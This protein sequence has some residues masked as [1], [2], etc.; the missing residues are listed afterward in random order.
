MFKNIITVSFIAPFL[1]LT[2][3]ADSEEG[4]IIDFYG[5]C[6]IEQA[7]GS[8]DPLPC[9]VIEDPGLS[10]Q[11]IDESVALLK[12][13]IN[14]EEAARLK[15]VSADLNQQGLSK[16]YRSETSTKYSSDDKRKAAKINGDDYI[17]RIVLFNDR[18]FPR[19][20]RR[21]GTY[22]VDA[23]TM[24]SNFTQQWDHTLLTELIGPNYSS[25]QSQVTGVSKDNVILHLLVKDSEEL[26]NILNGKKFAL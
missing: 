19:K 26:E 12:A 8:E 5:K 14:S 10:E 2:F 17:I 4:D 20:S 11:E 22:F 6:F 9:P 3:I 23:K 13:F 24:D 7:D 18:D 16:K 21:H 1:S 15:R 25:F